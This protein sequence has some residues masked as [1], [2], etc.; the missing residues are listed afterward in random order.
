[1][2]TWSPLWTTKLRSTTS[3]KVISSI[4]KHIELIYKVT[5]IKYVQA[6]LLSQKLIRYSKDNAVYLLFWRTKEESKRVN[7]PL[8]YNLKNY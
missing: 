2:A 1:M 3:P 5:F 4:K 7:T 8:E 6:K